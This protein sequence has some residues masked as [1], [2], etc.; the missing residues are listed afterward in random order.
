VSAPLYVRALTLYLV[1]HGECEHNLHRRIGAQDDTPLTELGRQQARA[2]GRLFKEMGLDFAALDFIASP[3]HRACATMELLRAEA[4]LPAAGYRADR[5][6]MEIDFGD[7]TG[8]TIREVAERTVGG[9]GEANWDYVRH[10]GE[11]VAMAYARVG[12]FLETLTRD[13]LIVTHA[14]VIRLIR[15]HVLGLSRADTLE[16]H[17]LNTGF[18]RL[19]AGTE[20]AFGA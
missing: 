16:Y 5:R 19:S 10:N 6:L 7:D 14:G 3:L 12:R 15:G 20:A 9:F 2:N 13:A 11:S 4:G 8:K 1:R 17:P 18:L